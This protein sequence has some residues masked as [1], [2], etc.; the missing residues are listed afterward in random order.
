[1][2][3][4]ILTLFCLFSLSL[5][6]LYEP[7]ATGFTFLKLG[8]G[9]RPVA[10][11][12]AFNAVSDDGNALFWNPAGLGI[13]PD[14]HLTG[15]G[16]N[17]LGF[18]NYFSLGTLIPAG[19][20]GGLGIGLSYLYAQDTRYDE[21]GQEQGTFTNSDLLGGIGYAYPF[22]QSL[23]G[24]ASLKFVR[25]QLAEYDAYSFISDVGL[26]YKPIEYLYLGSSLRNF[27]IPRKFIEKW[28]Y[29]PTNLRNG[30]ALKV[31]FLENHFILASDVSLYPDVAPTISVGAELALRLGKIMKV[32]TGQ[33]ISGFFLRAGYQT[34]YH[35]GTWGGL[36]FGFGIE[37]QAAKNLYLNIDGVYFSYGYLG[38]SERVSLAVRYAPDQGHRTSGRKHPSRSRR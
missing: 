19:D 29:P 20:Y 13:S 1:M 26:I 36:S 3:C 37:Y 25:S 7:G 16:M 11:G 32:V 10:M 28:E 24:G 18:V 21:T 23:S 22:I 9:A 30:V 31:P 33:S 38:E 6:W 4:K 5:G 15:M 34:G 35:L 14:F 8:I 12:N 2:A 27:G 17:M